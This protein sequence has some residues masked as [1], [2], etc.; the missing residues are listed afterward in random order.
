MFA[1][2]VLGALTDTSVWVEYRSLSTQWYGSTLTGTCGRI[3]Y[4]V[5]SAVQV[6]GTFALTR[7][8]VE[9]FG[10]SAT[11]F[12]AFTLTGL[13]VQR[14]RMETT[15]IGRTFAIA[16]LRVEV[17]WILAF[18]VIGTRTGTVAVI[19]YLI[20]WTIEL[21]GTNA[22]ARFWVLYFQSVAT[23]FRTHAATT[24]QVKY[25]TSWTS[26]ILWA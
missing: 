15:F 11:C 7:F 4:L 22:L 8:T 9:C 3:E 5:G 24:V 20:L 25:L 2:C 21:L 10:C 26:Q 23:T 17:E 19:K 1:L 14:F 6:F 12:G 18:L 16:R 13:V